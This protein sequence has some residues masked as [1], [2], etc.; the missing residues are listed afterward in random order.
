MLARQSIASVDL[1]P[2]WQRSRTFS[3]LKPDKRTFFSQNF[4]SKA[5]NGHLRLDTKRISVHVPDGALLHGVV[6]GEHG[7]VTEGD[8]PGVK[9]VL[10]RHQPPPF[11]SGDKLVQ[12][13]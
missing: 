7:L 13:Q 9:T 10:C 6:E 11:G 8:G 12:R 3:K 2:E 4:S 5:L 1:Q